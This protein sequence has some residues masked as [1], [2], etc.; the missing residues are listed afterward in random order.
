VSFAVIEYRFPFE[1]IVELSNTCQCSDGLRIFLIS[2]S[3]PPKI[4]NENAPK[5]MDQRMRNIE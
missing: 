3:F 4:K 2:K 1:R 5:V